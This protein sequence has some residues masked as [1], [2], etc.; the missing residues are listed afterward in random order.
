MK[1]GE[2]YR[3]DLDPVV[4]SEQGGIR[5]VVI[6]QND[7]GNQHSTTV[8]VAALTSRDKKSHLPVHVSVSAEETGLKKDS[9]ILTEQL[10][11]LEKSRLT[12]YLGQLT[13]GA[14]QRLDRALALSLGTGVGG[15][16][17]GGK[18]EHQG[19]ICQ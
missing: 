5:P 3:A 1:R 10:R 7:I 13:P 11:T 4:G 6:I 19:K 17:Q 15:C 9:V 14:M 16:T 2:I 8:I 12:R 18:Y